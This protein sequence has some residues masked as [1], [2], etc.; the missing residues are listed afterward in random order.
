VVYR[1]AYSYKK[2]IRQ[3]LVQNKPYDQMARERIAGKGNTGATRHYIK[4][5]SGEMMLPHEKMGEDVRVF[6]GIRLDCAQCHDHPYEPWAQDQFWGLTSFYGQLT[7]IRNGSVFF[8]DLAGNEERP[9]GPRVIHPRRREEVSPKFLDGTSID[10]LVGD[11]RGK[12]AN[13][14][15]S[16]NNPYFS[17]AI[18]NR[19][20]SYFFQRGLVEPVDDFRPSNPPTHPELLD[21]LASEFRR[22]GYDIKRLMRVITQSQTYQLSSDLNKTN[23]ADKVNYSRALPRRLDA[24]VLLD[25][26]SQVTGVPEIFPV[27]KYVGGGTEPTGTRAIHL[28]PEVTP[29]QFLEVFGRP[30]SRD[31]MPWRDRRA[32]LRQA[33]HLLVGSTYGSKISAKGGRVDLYLKNGVS[34][35][36]IIENLYLAAFSRYPTT[37]EYRELGVLMKKASSRKKRIEN[38]TWGLLA[39]REFTYN[40]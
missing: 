22:S 35:R 26:I 24:E 11:P 30:I 1:N 12:L 13:W 10:Q 7:R 37:K 28:I 18:V 4:S 9:E 25:A 20:W 29:S 23:E 6:L 36:Q 31:N 32:T 33:L 21:A 38:L 15:T 39:S 2:W 16:S 14:M 5:V 40:H 19:I 27:H 17:R 3:S 34:D 8:D